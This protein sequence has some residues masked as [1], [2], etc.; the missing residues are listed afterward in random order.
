MP[1]LT[2]PAIF[3]AQVEWLSKPPIGYYCFAPPS[4]TRIHT[5]TKVTQGQFSAHCMDWIESPTNTDR[6][7]QFQHRK[8][9]L[10]NC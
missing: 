4:D 1:P 3:P 9:I 10:C 2:P 5:N 8:A 6:R 7:V